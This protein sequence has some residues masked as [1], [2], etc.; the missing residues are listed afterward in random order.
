MKNCLLLLTGAFDSDGGIAALNRLTIAALAERH[1]LEIFTLAENEPKLDQRYFPQGCSVCM[2]A[3]AGTKL[4]FVFSAWRAI[5]FNR[6]DLIL[7]DHVNLASALAPL[8]WLRLAKYTVWLCGMEVFPPRPDFEGRLGLKNASRRLAIS[9]YTRQSVAARYPKIKIE[10]CDLSL[11]PVRHAPSEAL[12]E[13]A[14]E[15]ELTALDGTRLCLDRRV[16]LHVGRM[17]TL[18]RFKGQQ[19]LIDAFPLIH[20][21][22]PD[23]QLVLAGKGDDLERLRTRARS[24]P[25]ELHRN[26]FM[27][28]FVTDDMLERLYRRCALFAMPS[29]GEGFGLVYLEAMSRGKPCIGARADATP[30]VI[31]DGETGLLVDDA[32]SPAQV[33]EAVLWLFD[34]PEEA[35]RMG[36]AGYDLVQSYYLFPHFKERFWKA[37]SVG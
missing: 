20:A 16:I 14:G 29:I 33:A 28:G 6:Y 15:V 2:R 9:A 1:A 25:A 11:D 3:F 24:L 8:R 32:R 35:Q 19:V 30:C 26:I 18:E 21:K 4:N 37:L 7:V 31:R 22:Y 36:R 23:A 17:S 27:P 34:H 10:V 13:E 5:L 12:E